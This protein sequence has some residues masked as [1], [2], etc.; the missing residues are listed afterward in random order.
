ME[1][2]QAV[3]GMND[4]LPGAVE[5]WQRL[6]DVIREVMAEYAY[7][8]IRIPILERTTLFARSIGEQTDI[9][10]KEMYTFDDRNGDSLTLRPE[11]T[12]GCV[13]AGVQHGLFHN[14]QVRLWY[15]GPMFR[16]E[17]PQKGRYRQ[18]HQF[19]AEAIGWD[20]PDVD[21]ELIF[22]AGRVF[23]VLNIEGVE[24]EINSLGSPDARAK[25]HTYLVDYF[26]SRRDE[27]DADSLKRLQRNPL[28]ILDSKNPEMQSVIE[29][30]P[31]LIDHLDDESLRHFEGLCHCLDDAGVP[32]RINHRLVRGLDYYTRTVF[33][34][35]SGA[36]GAQSAVCAGGRYDRLVEQLGGRPT[37][38]AGYALG[39]E[40]LVELMR[41]SAGDHRSVPDAYFVTVGEAAE[42]RAV[43]LAESLR[44]Q[45]FRIQSNCGGG[46]LK[47]QMKRGDQ[48]GAG[49]AILLGEREMQ[50]GV[51]SIKPLRSDAQQELVAFDQIATALGTR[52]SQC[53]EGRVRSTKHPVRE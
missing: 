41:L 33:E 52:V 28:R 11:G 20:G 51:V 42:L 9:V 16:H 18:F 40:R 25:Y 49:F 13:R 4:I 8:E 44:D 21:A 12:V 37:P 7:Q 24:L 38:A 45:G 23:H 39:L 3:R 47:S 19:G 6:E 17:R 36:L 5:A 26:E 31:V 30:A 35:V 22:T 34:W 14:R 29:Q 46:S 48:S 2:I 1:L 15:L 10:E 43:Q 53:G 27:L 50:Q 32:Y